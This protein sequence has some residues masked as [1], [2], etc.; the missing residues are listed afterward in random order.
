VPPRSEHKGQFRPGNRASTRHGAGSDAQIR[1]VARAQKR[2]LLRQAGL[3][4]RDFD[5][6]GMALLDG[7]A[8]AQAKVEL[9][10]RWYEQHGFLNARGEPQGPSKVYVSLLN[11]ARLS[12]VRL[13]EHLRERDV[14]GAG[15]EALILEGRAIRARHE[16]GADT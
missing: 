2:R 16:N 11:S 5:G 12:A 4:I 6:V 13:G 9:C 10:D 8:R 14:A 1:P 3:R 7:W 15:I